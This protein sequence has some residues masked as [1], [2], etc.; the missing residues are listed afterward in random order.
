MSQQTFERRGRQDIV[1]QVLKSAENGERKTNLMNKANLN[2]AQ[3]ERYLKYLSKA[4]FIT[5]ES[6]VWTTTEKGLNVIEA[7]KI[8]R[9]LME[10]P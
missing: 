3:V 10:T 6:G 4:G 8:C 7:C 2:F 9:R 1:I 5:E